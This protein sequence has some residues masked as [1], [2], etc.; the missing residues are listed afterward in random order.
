MRRWVLFLWIILLFPVIRCASV[1]DTAFA[2]MEADSGAIISAERENER[3]PMASTTKIMTAL[4][5]LDKTRGDERVKISP[6]SAAIEGSKMYLTPGKTYT[7]DDLLYGLLLVSGNDAADALAVFVAGSEENFALLM[8]QKAQSIGLRNTH[9]AN[10]SGLDA[11]GHYSSAFD[12]AILARAALQNEKF[13]RIVCSKTYRVGGKT[14]VN[15][16]KLL[17]RIDGCIG[18]KTGF[19]KKSGRC[20][21][22]AVRKDH[23]TLICVTLHCPDDW[24]RHACLYRQAFQKCRYEQVLAEKKVYLAQRI[25]G[26]SDIGCYNKAVYA[27][28]TEEA[29]EIRYE[30]RKPLFSDIRVREGDI[31]GM[32]EVYNGK[33]LISKAPLYADRNAKARKTKIS[34]WNRIFRFFRRKNK[35]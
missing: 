13:A 6:Q 9:F 8:N 11:E 27:V 33:T 1:S 32:L 3:L 12:L 10:A 30:I 28:V 18:V 31:V 26:G 25:S 19:T 22:S 24:E 2:V 35:T 5:V 34:F 21:V 7:V 29:P 23:I 15:H 17:S 16:N 14:L 20:L 4:V